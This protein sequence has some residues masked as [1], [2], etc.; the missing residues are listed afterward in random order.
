[1]TIVILL[2]IFR[3]KIF[4]GI[5][6]RSDVLELKKDKNLL[7]AIEQALTETE[8]R[9]A[10]FKKIE[11]VGAAIKE[12][13]DLTNKSSVHKRHNRYND[14]SMYQQNCDQIKC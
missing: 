10:E 1:M 4:G 11:S 3:D 5:N 2:I 12:R 13:S 7:A 8:A 14:I 6:T 9:Q